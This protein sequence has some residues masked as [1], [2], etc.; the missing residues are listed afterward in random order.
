[1]YKTVVLIFVNSDVL[2]LLFDFRDK[3]DFVEIVVQQRNL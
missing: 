3:L 2:G 1:M